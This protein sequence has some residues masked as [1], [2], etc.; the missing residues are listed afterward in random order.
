MRVVTTPE[1]RA[2]VQRRGGKLF[3]WPDR[4]RCC[5]VSLTFLQTST[6]PPPE[7]FDY[8]R[9]DAEGFSVF[10]D[11][12]IRRLPEELEL[13]LRGRRRPH[14]EAYWDGCAYAI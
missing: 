1:A 5:R 14:V 2:F 4:H 11:P 7:A 13:Q 9:I 3:V 10:T 8:V 6:D 12:A